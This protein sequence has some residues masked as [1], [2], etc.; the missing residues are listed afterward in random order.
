MSVCQKSHNY[1]HPIPRITLEF[2]PASVGEQSEFSLRIVKSD[3]Q[4]A[5]ALS[6]PLRR[7]PNISGDPPLEVVGQAS[8]QNEGGKLES[9]E[10]EGIVKVSFGF[11]PLPERN[12]LPN[13]SSLNFIEK[14]NHTLLPRKEHYRGRNSI[15][16]ALAF[17]T[18][19][20]Y[21]YVVPPEDYDTS[22]P[23]AG[24]RFSYSQGTDTEE[25]RIVVS[26]ALNLAMQSM[27]MEKSQQLTADAATYLRF[28]DPTSEGKKEDWEV[29]SSVTIPGRTR[30]KLFANGSSSVGARGNYFS[31]EDISDADQGL[32][33]RIQP[34]DS[35]LA[36]GHNLDTVSNP[37]F[38]AMVALGSINRICRET[39]ALNQAA[40]QHQSA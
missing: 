4:N 26:S 29:L 5:T 34:G 18:N 31:P 3:L 12:Q 22:Q 23:P 14:V 25:P 21:Q 20:Q 27:S 24:A 2:D 39:I 40:E 32:D 36:I 11:T 33:Y 1:D 9:T 13:D 15:L 10:E 35:Y 7:F 19:L 28:L 37:Q 8:Q 30:D 6:P 38:I 16:K 17:I